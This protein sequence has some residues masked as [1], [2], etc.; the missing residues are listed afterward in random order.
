MINAKDETSTNE[1]K[2]LRH[3][4]SIIENPTMGVQGKSLELPKVVVAQSAFVGGT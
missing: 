4:Q 1:S 2:R 3:R